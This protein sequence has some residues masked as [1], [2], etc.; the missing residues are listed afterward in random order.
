MTCRRNFNGFTH[1]FDHARING[2]TADIV[3]R[4]PTSEVQNGGYQTGSTLCLWIVLTYRRNSNG[5]T[6]I[7][8]HSRTNGGNADIVR[9]RPTSTMQ[10]G[11]HQTGSTLY[12]R[13]E[14]TYRRI[15]NG[16]PDI[17]DLV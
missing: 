5:F 15:S 11:G 8:D 16:Y 13:N 10:N 4:Q 14:M 6:H 9:C 1:I 3:R 12:L 7:F 2:D 17:F